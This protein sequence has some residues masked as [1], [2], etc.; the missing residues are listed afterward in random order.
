M[1]KALSVTGRP[2]AFLIK[3]HPQQSQ[4]EKLRQ[5]YLRLRDA[6]SLVTA[7]KIQRSHQARAPTSRSR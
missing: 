7:Y 2:D 3:Q 6:S 4:F 1:L 5:E